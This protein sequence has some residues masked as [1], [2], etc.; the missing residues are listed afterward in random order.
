MNE[1]SVFEEFGA[2]NIHVSYFVFALCCKRETLCVAFNYCQIIETQII[3]LE[4]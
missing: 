1:C 3:R 4:N 2:P